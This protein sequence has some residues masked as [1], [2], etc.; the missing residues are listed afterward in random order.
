MVLKIRMYNSSWKTR[1]KVCFCFVRLCVVLCC[2][3]C[4]VMFFS[5]LS[6]LPSGWTRTSRIAWLFGK[7][8]FLAFSNIV[9]ITAW[10]EK[11]EAEGERTLLNERCSQ[12]FFQKKLYLMQWRFFKKASYGF[13][14]RMHHHN[15]GRFWN[16]KIRTWRGNES[17]DS[18][19]SEGAILWQDCVVS[20]TLVELMPSDLWKLEP[21]KV[22]KANECLE[23]SWITEC[24]C[25]GLDVRAGMGE[26]KGNFWKGGMVFLWL[27]SEKVLV[28]YETTRTWCAEIRK[29]M[30]K[31]KMEKIGEGGWSFLRH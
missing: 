6:C 8:F 19:A 31:K 23:L 22:I 15:F 30:T 25:H 17:I 5:F 28:E 13:Q 3:L 7:N 20:R 29:A 9:G 1:S 27:I 2:A 4:Y 10:E 18:G 11:M 12:M 26:E 14:H 24:L 16:V 21:V